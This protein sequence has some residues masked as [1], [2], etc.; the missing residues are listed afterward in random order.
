MNYDM[1]WQII[2]YLLLAG[3]GWLTSRGFLTSDTLTQVVGA[4]G[5]ILSAA[6]GTYVKWGTTSVPDSTAKRAD[7]P[8]VSPLS[9][10]VIPGRESTG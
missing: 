8:V 4:I 5:V 10:Q 6:W 9:G 1:V 2:R 7:V 3:G